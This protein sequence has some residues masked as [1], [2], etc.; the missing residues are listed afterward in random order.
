VTTSANYKFYVIAKNIVGKSVPSTTVEIYAAVVPN[1]PQ[2]VKRVTGTNTQN[3]INL[4]WT[5]GYN[6]GSQITG[7]QVWWNQGVE[8]G[9]I[10]DMK[11]LI[12]D[13]ATLN[14]LISALTPG[15]M[16]GFAVK[17]INVV[18]VSEFST[19]VYIMAATVADAPSVPVLIS[20]SETKIDLSWTPAVNTG[21]TPLTLYK[22]YWSQNE[23]QTPVHTIDA[24]TPSVSV[25]ALDGVVTG[26]IYSFYV[27]S[28][29]YIGDSLPSPLLEDIV[30]GSLPT[31]PNNF[32]RATSVTPV[33][34]KISIQWE[35]PTN[36]GGSDILSYRI[37][38]DAGN[39]GAELVFLIS[40]SATTTFHT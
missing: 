7:Y 12:N 29:N 13:A 22:V 5:A 36:D 27:V 23:Y 32:K 18:G 14:T 37:E 35:P 40:T 20:Q 1:P 30:A 8:N 39:P 31:M 2:N 17:A 19:T 11:V 10:T 34:T 9:P 28:T 38:W 21:G 6:G 15:M 24:E 25:T 26:E 16:Y 4:Q 33:D 3:S